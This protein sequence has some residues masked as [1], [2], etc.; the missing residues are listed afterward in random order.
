[1]LSFFFFCETQKIT[2]HFWLNDPPPPP[3]LLFLVPNLQWEVLII[4]MTVKKYIYTVLD[5][6]WSIQ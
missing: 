4:V 6:D 5:A 2:V 1:M 3:L